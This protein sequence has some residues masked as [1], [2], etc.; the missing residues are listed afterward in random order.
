VLRRSVAA[1]RRLRGVFRSLE[2]LVEQPSTKSSLKRLSQLFGD[3]KPLG[4]YV[5]PAQTVCN[6]WNYF[7]TLLPEHLTER[8]TI[9]YSQRVSLIS[10][11][12]GPLTVNLDLDG[13]GP[14]P[15]TLGI[16]VP[17]EVETGMSAAGYSGAQATGRTYSPTGPGTFEPRHLPILHANPAGP[18]GQDGEN[19]QPGQTG[20]ILGQLRVPGQGKD[21]PSV[22]VPDL[23]G[24]Q[25]PT[26][27]FWKQD[28]TRILKDT[29]VE[30]RQ[31]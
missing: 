9:G 15:P 12:L 22:L 10:S 8:D 27:A 4:N 17:G 28:G 6:Y 21:N 18:T 11:P 20:Y 26:T 24:D 16:T 19:C 25:G 3:A 14:V 29:R 1:N 5:V 31:P 30:S 2:S 23:P 7:W 13:T